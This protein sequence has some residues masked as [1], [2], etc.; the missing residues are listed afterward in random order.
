MGRHK[1]ESTSVHFV[2]LMD[3]EKRLKLF[4]FFLEALIVKKSKGSD[5]T[6]ILWLIPKR[7]III[8]LHSRASSKTGSGI[9][10][11]FHTVQSTRL[12]S[13]EPRKQICFSLLAQ[14]SHLKV[15]IHLA[16][17]RT[18]T[19]ALTLACFILDGALVYCFTFRRLNSR[20]LCCFS[21]S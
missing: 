16:F 4:H 7:C 11:C 14:A 20:S 18:L 15:L 3:S 6:N 2:K 9:V 10:L 5:I 21:V 17:A 12:F 13:T 1:C 8:F 19:R